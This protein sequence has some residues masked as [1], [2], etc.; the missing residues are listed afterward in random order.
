MGDSIGA[1][2]EQCLKLPRRLDLTAARGLRADLLA[3]SGH[4]LR[5]DA[6]DVTHLGGLCLQLLLA[7]ANHWRLSDQPLAI[8]PRSTAFDAALMAFGIDRSDLEQRREA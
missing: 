3:L 1:D 4:P 8:E 6:A 2:H 5:L 7:A